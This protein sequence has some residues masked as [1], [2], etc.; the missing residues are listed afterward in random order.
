[1]KFLYLI[2]SPTNT[3]DWEQY[4]TDDRTFII[5]VWKDVVQPGRIDLHNTTWAAGRNK[6]FEY[7]KATGIIEHYEYI[8]FVDDDLTF[9]DGHFDQY[10]KFLVDYDIKLAHPAV[11]QP[12]WEWQRDNC[13][14]NDVCWYTDVVDCCFST[15]HKSVIHQCFPYRTFLDYKNWWYSCEMSNIEIKNKGLRWAVPSNVIVANIGHRSYPKV[16]DHTSISKFT[17]FCNNFKLSTLE[18]L[19]IP[20]DSH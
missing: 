5:G 10:E 16:K 7:I 17:N 1:V 18:Q 14:A 13:E 20:Y 3:H 19:C 12:H 15:F 8:T 9:A 4:S 2:Q 11:D 6:T